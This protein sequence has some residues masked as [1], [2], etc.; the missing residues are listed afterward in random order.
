MKVFKP[1]D[2]NK[3]SDCQFITISYNDFLEHRI[4]CLRKH[5][6]NTAEVKGIDTR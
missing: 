4:R 5:K 3:C 6:A 2:I 1:K